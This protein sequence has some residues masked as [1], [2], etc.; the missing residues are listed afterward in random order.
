VARPVQRGPEPCRL[1]F[2]GGE[3]LQLVIDGAPVPGRLPLAEPLAIQP[4]EH[5]IVVRGAGLQPYRERLV[6]SPGE[7]L[8]VR[9]RLRAR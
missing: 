3:G 8:T 5:Q 9:L 1:G 4:G 6:C 7:T 2:R